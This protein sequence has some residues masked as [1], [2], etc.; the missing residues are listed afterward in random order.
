MKSQDIKNLALIYGIKAELDGMKVENVIRKSNNEAPAYGNEEFI[1]Q[2]QELRSLAEQI[3]VGSHKETFLDRLIV[4][5]K[6]LGDKI[7]KLANALDHHLIP[8]GSITINN[9][10]L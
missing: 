4:E 6:E 1:Y 5:K 2:S 3:G 9:W 8:E 10:L 7:V